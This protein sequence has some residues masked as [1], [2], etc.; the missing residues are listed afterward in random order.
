MLITTHRSYLFLGKS[1]LLPSGNKVFIVK[2][3]CVGCI[4]GNY[5]EVGDNTGGDSMDFDL[6]KVW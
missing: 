4:D 2:S 5:K 1:V 3:V 6:S